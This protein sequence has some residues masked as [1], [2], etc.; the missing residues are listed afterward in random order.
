MLFWFMCCLMAVWMI[1]ASDAESCSE[2]PAVDN[3]ISVSKEDGEQILRTYLCIRGYHLVGEKTIFCNA[4]KG[5]NATSPQCQWGHC[6]DPFLENGKFSVL[7][8]VDVN[9]TVTFKCNEDYILKGSSWSRCL[10]NH[11]WVP[12]F[13]ICKSRNCNS[14]ENITHGYF[15]G[16]DFT[17]GSTITYYCEEG[18]CLVGTQSQQCIDGDWSSALPVC[19]V[20]QEATKLTAQE[21]FEKEFLAFQET[22]DLRQTIENIMQK[23]KKHNLTMEEIKYSLEIM[24]AK[25]KMLKAKMLP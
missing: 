17:S 10:E 7:Q 19:E 25:A 24:K 13:P 20:I 9:D 23:F 16:V 12:P 15:E 8:P 2:I 4:S 18:Y 1:S 22:E 3:S 11:T 6:P 5:W 14:P 21:Q